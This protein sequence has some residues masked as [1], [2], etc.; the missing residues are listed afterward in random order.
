MVVTNLNAGGQTAIDIDSV[1]NVT[2]TNQFHLISYNAFNGSLANFALGTVPVRFTGVL[3]NNAVNHSIDLVVAK[4]PVLTPGISS[5]L[6]SA[7]DGTLTISGTNGN[8][9]FSYY[10]LTSTN[11]ALP[12]SNWSVIDVDAFDPSGNFTFIV[13]PDPTV[14]PQF[15]R[16]QVP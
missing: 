11:V 2:G 13:Y 4:A 8:A 14:S 10:V 9:G 1:T 5:T 15:Y 3:S 16:L 7:A 6:Y 12:L